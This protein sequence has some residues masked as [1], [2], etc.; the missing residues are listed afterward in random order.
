MH[1][2]ELVL[3]NPPAL[4]ERPPIQQSGTLFIPEGMII[5][6]MNP[7]ILSLATYLDSKNF[8]VTI[9]DLSLER[10]YGA[11]EKKVQ[12]LDS[13]LVGISSTSGFDYIESLK[14]ASMVKKYSPDSKIIFG[15]QH[16]GP[17]GRIILEDNKDIDAV[18]KYEGEITLQQILES[19]RKGNKNPFNLPGVVFR[20]GQ[21]I[22]EN[23][24]RP[25]IV[26]LD[27]LPPL[28]YSL[29]PDYAKFTPFVEESRGC[30]FK[31]KYCTSNTVY[32]NKINLKTPK[33]FLDEMERCV[34]LFGKDKAVA[35]LAST[36]GVN[37]KF[38]KEIAKGMKKFGIKWNSEFRAD[39]PWEQ[40]IH[41]LLD[42]GYEVVNVGVESG[43]PEILKLMGKT[44][45]PE[46]YLR[47]MKKL[48]EII[49]PSDAVIRANF[50][51]YAGETPKTIGETIKFLQ[52][53]KGID[54]VQFS[55]LLAFHGTP[56]LNEFEFYRTRFGSEIVDSDYW[57]SRHLYPVHP[58]KYFSFQEMA[59]FGQT[60][61]KIFSKEEAWCNAAKSLYTQ[62]T[63]EARE[64]VKKNLTLSRFRR[65]E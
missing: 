47:K 59:V 56:L 2:N 63:E 44:N 64:K 54:S 27:D 10:D 23:S 22:S 17:L 61:E 13:S 8:D 5:T 65:A 58:S 52:E 50:M 16:A 9:L 34:D 31:C 55:P 26:P 7:G 32:G 35:V 62:E 12:R 37:P 11:L 51:F 19:I 18:V 33:R 49:S 29:Y 43:S 20:E 48:A 1:K 38:G 40:Y 57:K 21:K 45:Q 24:G 39:S 60:L 6:A 36:Y 41:E 14:I 3:I 46:E 28:E 25:K 30:V 53:T 15:G 42:S 4:I